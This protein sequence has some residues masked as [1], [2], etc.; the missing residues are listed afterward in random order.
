MKV[1]LLLDDK[2]VERYNNITKAYIRKDSIVMGH[3][4]HTE[5]GDVHDTIIVSLDFIRIQG[6]SIEIYEDNTLI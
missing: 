4:T 5:K 6:Y 2:I 1:A 3:I